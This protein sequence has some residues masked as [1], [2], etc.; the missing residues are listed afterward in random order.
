MTHEEKRR[1]WSS[2]ED[3]THSLTRSPSLI[4]SSIIDTYYTYISF[5]FTPYQSNMNTF[6]L[7]LLSILLGSSQA[8][9]PVKHYSPSIH[10]H[11]TSSSALF[12][13]KQ[14]TR[15]TNDV[16]SSRRNFIQ[17]SASI[18]AITF[19]SQPNE[20]FAYEGTSKVLV[21]GGSGFVG[22]QIC[23]KLQELNI[24]YIATSRDGRGD[25]VPLDFLSDKV[26]ATVAELAKDCT[27]VISTVGAIGSS[28][29]IKI[30]NSGTGLASMGAKTA[31]VKQ[32]VYISVAPEVRESVGNVDFFKN[33]MQGK[34]LSEDAIKSNFPDSYT[35]V[36]P[37]FIYGGDSFGINPPR[38]ADGYGRL[39]EGLL[40]S[41]PFRAAASVS[42]GFI[43]VALEPPVKVTDVAGACVAGALGK[44][45]HILDTYDEIVQ[46]SKLI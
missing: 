14:D 39:V 11:T 8:F 25:T 23:Q 20:A 31:G 26:E 36:A 19:L 30:V 28:E 15:N 40:S 35:I 17:T 33:Y 22:T 43:G 3:S 42:P 29:E 6:K 44:S 41:P 37:T 2:Q 10:H 4:T 16:Q 27:A 18:A 21:I 32:F 1:H 46:T 13:K 38:V 9:T 24:N 45:Q 5:Y 34:A 12:S 7:F